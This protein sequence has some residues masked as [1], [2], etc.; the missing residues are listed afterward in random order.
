MHAAL[1]TGGDIG[2]V[3]RAQRYE[4]LIQEYADTGDCAELRDATEEARREVNAG[5][6]YSL[7]P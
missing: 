7:A 4:R 1:T 5:G 3:E 6:F 2:A